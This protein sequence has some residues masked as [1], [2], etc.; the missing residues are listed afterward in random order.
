M[1][2]GHQGVDRGDE[3]LIAGRVE[4]RAVVPDAEQHICTTGTAVTE[5]ALNELEL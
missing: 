3:F 2:S 5:I 4:Q 1:D